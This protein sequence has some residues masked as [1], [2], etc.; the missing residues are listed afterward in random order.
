MSLVTKFVLAVIL[1]ALGL[2]I[3]QSWIADACYTDESGELRC[4][5]IFKRNPMTEAIKCAYYRCYDGCTKVESKVDSR[6]FDCSEFCKYQEWGIDEK[7]CDENAKLHPVKVSLEEE[8]VLRFYKKPYSFFGTTIDT[9][10]KSGS[11]GCF[12]IMEIYTEL[13][14]DNDPDKE[15]KEAEGLGGFEMCNLRKGD[16]YIWAESTKCGDILPP[17]GSPFPRTIL[18]G[19]PISS[20]SLKDSCSPPE[21]CC[22][23]E[24]CLGCAIHD[25]DDFHG[26]C[27]N[28]ETTNQIPYYWIDEPKLHHGINVPCCEAAD[29]PDYYCYTLNYDDWTCRT[30]IDELSNCVD[31]YCIPHDSPVTSARNTC[32]YSLLDFGTYADSGTCLSECKALFE[33]TC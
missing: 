13:I 9:C 10:K 22:E 8:Q 16:Y 5:W 33:A 21:N 32:F 12:P 19:H 26:V 29:C 25:Y 1:L 17:R 31:N 15:C 18:C 14:V 27:Y 23:Q 6:I 7:I 24:D 11:G 2:W 20:C 28:G 30:R 3:V 4:E